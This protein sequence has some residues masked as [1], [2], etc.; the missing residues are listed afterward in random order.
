MININDI[1]AKNPVVP[2]VQSDDPAAAVAISRALAAGGLTVVEVV[3]RT[4][5][6]KYRKSSPVPVP[7]CQQSRRRLRSTAAQSLSFR[8]GST[9]AL[10]VSRKTM[11]HQFT[12][13]L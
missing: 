8:L 1:L 9:M 5:L 13:E 3:F 2:L 10:W 11:T 12:P 6:M 4:L 7:C